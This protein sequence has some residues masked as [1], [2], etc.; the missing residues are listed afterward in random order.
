MSASRW[1]RWACAS[2]SV[3]AAVGTMA[4][5][6]PT[7][8]AAES[9]KVPA[10]LA[11]FYGQQPKWE[12]CAKD[13]QLAK[14]QCATLVVPMNY[15]KPGDERISVT[16]SK[17]PAKDT[18]KRRGVLLI[19]PGGPGGSGLSMPLAFADRPIA[20]TYDLIGF[21]PRGV[22]RSTP[23][24]CEYTPPLGDLPSRPTD[25]QFALFTAQAQTEESDCER[26]AG[27]LRPYV[28]TPN[29]AR[30]MDVIRGVLGEKKINYLG[31]SYGTYLG[32]VFGSLFP[33]SL[34]RNVLDSSV[35][36]DWIWREQFKEQAVAMRANVDA[37][38]K[39]LGERNSV[40]G[41]G[42]SQAEVFATTEALAAKLADK[43]ITNPQ[44]GKVDRTVYDALV[45]LNSRYRPLW[46]TLGKL[47]KT[48]KAAADGTAAADS[49]AVVDAGKAA[50]LLNDLG[51]AQTTSGVFQTVTCEADWPKDLSIYYS[52]M[53]LYREKYP[54]GYG[55]GRA[56]ANPCTFR[57]FALTDKVTDLKRNGYPTGL[58]IQAEGDS[59]TQYD[60]G[61]AMATKLGDQ[62]VSV[63]DEGT[64][65]LYSRNACASDII[66]RYLVDGVLP[67]T[68]TTCAGDPRPNVPADGK[69]ALAP[70]A[71]NEAPS[72]SLTD[73]VQQYISTK[74][75][76][77]GVF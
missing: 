20:Q 2:L 9:A 55:V 3:M 11:E 10:G 6:A 19:N 58:V 28:N 40:Y 76:T 66:D 53:K 41:L 30:D 7:A 25:E 63:A 70:R 50:K 5:L 64:H 22:G 74:K 33:A 60:G 17:L 36:P 39:W 61:P 56:A 29:T 45:G 51:I 67:G 18:A 4:G 37:F 68:R 46:D 73:A 15:R 13:G 49:A 14:L 32:A 72:T 38:Y 34:D 16:I 8:L 42:K 57:N 52:D 65:G 1:S 31:F 26:A 27:G 21:D 75:L 59:Q 71:A 47:V 54:Y 24:L 77:A 35:S 69:T 23:L 62:L 12:P 48:F 44:F 43:P